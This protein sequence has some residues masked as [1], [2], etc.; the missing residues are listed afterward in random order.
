MLDLEADPR[1]TVAH[2]RAIVDVVARPASGPERAEV[3]ARALDIYVGYRTYPRRVTGRRV[4][5]F[6]LDPPAMR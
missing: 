4:R 3:L 5:V 1:A 6:V 2:G